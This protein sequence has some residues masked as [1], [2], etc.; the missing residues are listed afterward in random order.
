MNKSSTPCPSSTQDPADLLTEGDLRGLAAA[1]K[2]AEELKK[3]Y[4]AGHEFPLLPVHVSVMA[5]PVKKQD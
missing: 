5:G 4:A 3:K 2:L 1:R